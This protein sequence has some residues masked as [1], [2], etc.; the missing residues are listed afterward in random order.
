VCLSERFDEA[1]RLLTEGGEH[2]VFSFAPNGTS[3]P[4][5]GADGAPLLAPVYRILMNWMQHVE[6]NPATFRSWGAI[7]R[8]V[9]D[10][11]G[12]VVQGLRD[13]D[14]S[15][16]DSDSWSLRRAESSFAA[17]DRLLVRVEHHELTP[18]AAALIQG[19]GTVLDRADS[20]YG[21]V[22]ACS[23][24]G[25]ASPLFVLAKKFETS[26]LVPPDHALPGRRPD[27]AVNIRHPH[28]EHALSLH[29]SHP[30]LALYILAKAL[31]LK[32]DRLLG[33]DPALLLA[34][35]LAGGTT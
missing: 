2:V 1:V 31:L 13:W 33:L 23:I 9:A 34:A 26:M 30:S 28:F 14:F 8:E 32:E 16:L 11:T 3:L 35:Q 12:V 25:G 21:T 15:P 27:V 29:A 22:E 24:S 18:E 20:G 6:G 10:Y 19:T 4:A 17:A 5:V 7:A